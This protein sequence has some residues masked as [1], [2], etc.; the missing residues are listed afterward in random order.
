M[1]LTYTT[2]PYF[3]IIDQLDVLGLSNDNFA[4]AKII[5]TI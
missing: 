3:L 2:K 1:Y 5:Y 4:N